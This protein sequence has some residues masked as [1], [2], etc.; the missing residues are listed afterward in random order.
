LYVEPLLPYAV[1]VSG[2][3]I[4]ALACIFKNI[5]VSI[6]EGGETP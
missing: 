5:L 6:V 2:T 4:S 3:I 1:D